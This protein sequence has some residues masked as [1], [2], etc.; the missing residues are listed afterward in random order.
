MSR[1][2]LFILILYQQQVQIIAPMRRAGVEF[3]AGTD[4]L[5]PF[6][7]PGFS[8]HDELALL[9]AAGLT[10]MEALQAATRNPARYLGTIGA[11]GATADERKAG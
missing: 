1:S 6:C 11:F 9:V 2:A 10:P 5:N 4:A 7:F 3:L 8:L